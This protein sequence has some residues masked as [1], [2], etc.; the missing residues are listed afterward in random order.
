M[1]G[2]KESNQSGPSIG[3]LR[4]IMFSENYTIMQKVQQEGNTD[5]I[6]L[7]TGEHLMVESLSEG[8]RISD[9]SNIYP[10]RLVSNLERELGRKT[11][12]NHSAVVQTG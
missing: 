11:N 7:E 8:L 3:D 4:N 9:I 6:M 1:A 5:D 2:Q 10:N 12:F